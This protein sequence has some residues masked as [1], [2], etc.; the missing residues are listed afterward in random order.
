MRR[1]GTGKN[2]K[3]VPLCSHSV[4]WSLHA[5]WDFLRSLIELHYTF[6]QRLQGC[7]AESFQTLIGGQALLLQLIISKSN[8]LADLVESSAGWLIGSCGR[9]F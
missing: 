9:R 5:A 7:E 2:Q 6:Q 3:N 4:S 1:Y 8:T